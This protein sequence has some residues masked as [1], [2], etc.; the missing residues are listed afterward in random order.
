MV[1]SITNPEESYTVHELIVACVGFDFD[2]SLV[3][4]MRYTRGGLSEQSFA[5][6][7]SGIERD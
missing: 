7:E 5:H 1:L 2:F 6:E 3:V 4:A